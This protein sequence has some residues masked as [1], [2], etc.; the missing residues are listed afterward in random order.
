MSNP[1]HT[2]TIFAIASA[3]V[4]S[5]ACSEDSNKNS[6]AD[7]PTPTPTVA[8]APT[9]PPAEVEKGQV[10]I[11]L[12]ANSAT[13]SS[14]AGTGCV[15]CGVENLDAI[16]DA[17]P[18]NFATANLDVALLN[19]LGSQVDM[20]AQLQ[21][22]AKLANAVDPGVPLPLDAN[23]PFSAELP[24]SKPGFVISFPD[25][26]SLTVSLFPTVDI[27]VLREGEVVGGPQSYG[28]G[29]FDAIVVATPLQDINN[30]RVY[31]GVDANEP[32]DEI[33]LTLSGSVAD[34]FIPLN[35]HQTA[36]HGFAGSIAGDF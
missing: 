11:L 25:V 4:L 7:D 15:S 22:S 36:L 2:L 30:A 23:D 12:T 19:A 18:D 9:A 1:I 32:Y 14:A 33:R 13:A 10:N 21:V 24:P 5:S 27:E 6:R 26:S 35:I 16:L 3:A 31:L 29:F 28:F 20:G 8:P 34:L 17:D